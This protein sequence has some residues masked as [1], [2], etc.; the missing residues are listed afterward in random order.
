MSPLADT[1]DSCFFFLMI[2]RPPRSTLFP[3]TTLFRPPPKPPRGLCPQWTVP[4]RSPGDDLGHASTRDRGEGAAMTWVAH[5][6]LGPGGGDFGHGHGPYLVAGATKVV[7]GRRAWRR[8]RG[9]E[10]RTN[11]P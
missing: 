10:D 7:A 11:P 2:R 5:A 9:W 6:C 4:A 8:W 1:Y 3:Y